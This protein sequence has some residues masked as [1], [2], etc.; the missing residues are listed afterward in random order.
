MAIDRENLKKW[1]AQHYRKNAELYKER[2]KLYQDKNKDKIRVRKRKYY[3]NN[4][5]RKI[6]ANK[7]RRLRNMNA[8]PLWGDLDLIRDMYIEAASITAQTG[9]EQHVD[10][11]DPITHPLVC[12]LHVYNNLQILSKEV[13]LSKNNKFTP[14]HVDVEGT[15]SQIPVDREF[16]EQARLFDA[17][18]ERPRLKK[19]DSKKQL[20]QKSKRMQKYV[21]TVYHPNGNIEEITNMV[22]FCKEHGL[23]PGNMSGVI[24]GK[25]KDTK[26]YRAVI[27]RALD[28][29]ELNLST[30]DKNY[31]HAP[32]L[33]LNGRVGAARINM[34][35]TNTHTNTDTINKQK[36]ELLSFK[37]QKK[38]QLSSLEDQARDLRQAIKDIDTKLNELYALESTNTVLESIIRQ[39]G[40]DSE[41]AKTIQYLTD[42]ALGNIKDANYNKNGNTSAERRKRSAIYGTDNPNVCYKSPTDDD[43]VLYEVFIAFPEPDSV[44]MSKG[45]QTFLLNKNLAKPVHSD[46]VR[47]KKGNIPAS[48]TIVLGKEFIDGRQLT[49]HGCSWDKLEEILKFDFTITPDE[50]N[51]SKLDSTNKSKKS[52]SKKSPPPEGGDAD[53]LNLPEGSPI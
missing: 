52:N 47:D 26:G 10:H 4:K 38:E 28:K 1:R 29:E 30:S 5:A 40:A 7:L 15:V 48:P 37:D 3:E 39:F 23:S 31:N 25:K 6:A 41:E 32:T 33:Y 34:I 45:W 46:K 49:L 13:N 11:I 21:Y 51:K 14:Y 17:F 24:H 42:K 53:L 8:V 12:G 36:Q 9:V 16:I 19:R 35:D 43:K 50:Q 2:V 18:C 27:T 44:Q 22:K 20:E